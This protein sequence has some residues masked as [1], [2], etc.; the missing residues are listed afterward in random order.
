MVTETISKEQ[1][2]SIAYFE[3]KLAFEIGP[4]ELKMGQERGESYQIIDL[5]SPELFAKGH[6]PGARN[7]LIEALETELESLNKEQSVVVYCYDQFC[8]LSTKAALLLAKKGYKARELAGGF[9]TWADKDF[10]VEGKS[11]KSSCGSSCAS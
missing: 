4:V 7:I 9:N 5:R 10:A 11:T 6:I 8:H 1:A 3:S 2:A